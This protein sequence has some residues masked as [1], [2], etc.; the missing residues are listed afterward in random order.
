MITS[1]PSI[2]AGEVWCRAQAGCALDVYHGVEVS[3][4]RHERK[5]RAVVLAWLFHSLDQNNALSLF[6]KV[7]QLY[8]DVFVMDY[9]TPERNL[10]F[11]AYSYWLISERLSSHAAS[12]AAYIRGGGLERLPCLLQERPR[13]RFGFC[14]GAVGILW[15]TG[16]G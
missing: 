9:R 15:Y 12:Y 8:R 3:R 2:V 6:M 1:H 7:R 4:M 13:G 11:P 14:G 5:E 10:D 16:R